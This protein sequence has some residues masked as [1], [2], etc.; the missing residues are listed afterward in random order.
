MTEP[1]TNIKMIETNNKESPE[2][3]S[4][5]QEHSHD[6]RLLVKTSKVSNG[7]TRY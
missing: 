4:K 5:E 1:N 2:K 3:K 7:L 6:C